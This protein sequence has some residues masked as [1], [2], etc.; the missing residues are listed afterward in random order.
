MSNTQD[1]ILVSR[2]ALNY[3]IRLALLEEYGVREYHFT[4]LILV[5]YWEQIGHQPVKVH[6]LAFIHVIDNLGSSFGHF[7]ATAD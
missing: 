6:T 2:V 5:A 1:S 3:D 7:V 4:P